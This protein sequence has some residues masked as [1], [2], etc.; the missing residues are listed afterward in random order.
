MSYAAHQVRYG[1]KVCADYAVLA[2]SS[3]LLSS[4]VC[5]SRSCLRHAPARAI[6]CISLTNVSHLLA[7]G[8]GQICCPRFHPWPRF[9]QTAVLSN[10]GQV[11]AKS[12]AFVIET[13]EACDWTR[14]FKNKK[15]R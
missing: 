5:A 15:V 3:P 4:P 13:H 11:L 14:L 9:L 2:P 12:D 7:S 8:C 1:L 10:A 6:M